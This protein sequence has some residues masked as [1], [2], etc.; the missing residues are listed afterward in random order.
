MLTIG[1]LAAASGASVRALRY[2]EEQGLL[3]SERSSGNQRR[4]DPAAVDRIRWIRH[5][6]A[7]GLSSRTLLELLP[8]MHS[9]H[10]TEAMVERV[11]E[12]RDDIAA[13]IADLEATRERLDS[14]L[15]QTLVHAG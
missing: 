3:T 4:Y 11:R 10:A 1:D 9:G 15:A 5:L 7:A 2:Y 6:L 8:C 12:T 13:Q 14:V